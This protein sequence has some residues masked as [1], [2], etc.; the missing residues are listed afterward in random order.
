LAD[1]GNVLIPQALVEQLRRHR[2]AT[3]ERARLLISPPAPLA[4]VPF[5]FLG[6]GVSEQASDERLIEL[7]D[8]Q[9]IPSLQV[10]ASSDASVPDVAQWPLAVAGAFATAGLEAVAALHGRA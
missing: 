8:V 9:T 5:A 7:T 10:G 3:N 4:F 6:V 2:M 1:A